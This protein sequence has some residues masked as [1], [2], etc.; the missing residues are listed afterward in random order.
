MYDKAGHLAKVVFGQGSPD[1]GILKI[2]KHVGMGMN[3]GILICFKR[4]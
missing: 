4:F 3:D 2:P 1:N